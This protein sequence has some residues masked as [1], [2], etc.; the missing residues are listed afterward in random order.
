MSQRAVLHVQVSDHTHPEG[1]TKQF[2]RRRFAVSG[3]QMEKYDVFHLYGDIFLK[4]MCF[5][6]VSDERKR[7]GKVKNMRPL[8]TFCPSRKH[9]Q[10]SSFCLIDL[11]LHLWGG[12]GGHRK[13]GQISIAYSRKVISIYTQHP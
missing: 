10:Q 2:I 11:S 1:S 13:P 7:A 9:I 12:G 8:R 3:K 6:G 4:K 5:T